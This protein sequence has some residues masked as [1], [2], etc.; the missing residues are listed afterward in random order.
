MGVSSDFPLEA[1]WLEGGLCLVGSFVLHVTPTQGSNV[2]VA[3]LPS[4]CSLRDCP[5][6]RGCWNLPRQQGWRRGGG[7]TGGQLSSSCSP[8][9]APAPGP[10]L[11]RPPAPTHAGPPCLLICTGLC[12]IVSTLRES[13]CSCHLAKFRLPAG[14]GSLQNFSTASVC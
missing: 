9:A 11:H 14:G 8:A 2:R 5:P 6:Q 13:V 3:A 7:L 10:S 4:V 12:T 1:L